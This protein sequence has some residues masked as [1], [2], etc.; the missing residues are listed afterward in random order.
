MYIELLKE[1]FAEMV[2]KK[3]A[4]LIP[5][6][7]H[8][9]FELFANGQTQDY[10]YFLDFHEKV[11]QTD[12]QYKVNYDNNAFIEQGEKVAARIFFII[13]KSNEPTK[14]LEV[15]LISQFKDNKI[16]RIWEL[17]HPDWTKMPVFLQ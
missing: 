4:T 13:S 6:Y 7:Y 15:I 17:C 14:E 2:E 8:K 10:K 16:F 5:H 3:N 11:Y 1:M 12:I 9:N